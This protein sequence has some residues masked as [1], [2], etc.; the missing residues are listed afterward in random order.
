MTNGFA[1]QKQSMQCMDNKINNVRAEIPVAVSEGI[2]PLQK[3]IREVKESQKEQGEAQRRQAAVLKKHTEDIGKIFKMLAADSTS[4]S[5]VEST[6]PSSQRPVLPLA[7]VSR[8]EET[9]KRA[10]E[11]ESLK[12]KVR[13]ATEHVT[14]LLREAEAKRNTAFFRRSNNAEED[15]Y[16]QEDDVENL[17]AE[18][19]TTGDYHWQARGKSGYAVTFFASGTQRGEDRAAR[20]VADVN[21]K[22]TNI[23]AVVERPQELRELQGRAHDFGAAFKTFSSKVG[24][25]VNTFYSIHNEFLIV[26]NVVV[27]PLALIPAEQSWHNIFCALCDVLESSPTKVN[28]RQPLKSQLWEHVL[29]V[30]CQADDDLQLN[31]TVFSSAPV[32]RALVLHQE[33]A[34][35]PKPHT[36]L[37]INVDDKPST[38]DLATVPLLDSSGNGNDTAGGSGSSKSKGKKGVAQPGRNAKPAATTASKVAKRRKIDDAPT[39]QPQLELAEECMDVSVHD[40]VEDDSEL[41]HGEVT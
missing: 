40:D 14:K 16:L 12:E 31:K 17:L 29:R 5:P 26:G 6:L 2:Q 30:V 18:F 34:A 33:P 15:F 27:A 39:A 38:A 13:T 1:A 32:K 8:A 10:E 41:E 28:Y 23:W 37:L 20:F 3:Q 7:P 21:R 9:T 4:T 25:R 36:P 19:A 22:T 24:R 35:L 11:P